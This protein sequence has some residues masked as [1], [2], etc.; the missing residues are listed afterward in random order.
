MVMLR[1]F[2]VRRGARYLFQG[3]REGRWPLILLGLTVL[4]ARFN[5]RCRPYRS[6]VAT[7]RVKPGQTVGLRVSRP[8]EA[9]A[10]FRVE[11]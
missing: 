4:V 2:S 11:S 3:L 10:T 9:S 6:R 5:K 1:F 8:G 7:V